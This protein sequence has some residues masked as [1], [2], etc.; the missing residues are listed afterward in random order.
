MSRTDNKRK[1][2]TE[3][4]THRLHCNYRAEDI[5]S[6]TIERVLLV[7]VEANGIMPWH[8]SRLKRNV[9]K[10]ANSSRNEASYSNSINPDDAGRS[11]MSNIPWRSNLATKELLCT[12]ITRLCFGSMCWEFK[13]VDIEGKLC[14]VWEG[15]EK[16]NYKQYNYPKD[17]DRSQK[18]FSFLPGTPVQCHWFCNQFRRIIIWHRDT[19]IVPFQFLWGYSIRLAQ[20]FQILE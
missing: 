16:L 4:L 1:Y 11:S 14:V 5:V 6:A 7:V 2:S 17:L 9:W 18:Y 15:R 20:P 10:W 19:L 8:S 13:T 3:I 12:S